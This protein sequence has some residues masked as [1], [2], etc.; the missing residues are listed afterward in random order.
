MEELAELNSA[1]NSLVAVLT[2]PQIGG[3]APALPD[4][5]ALLLGCLDVD[6]IW[7]G[8]RAAI[9]HAAEN[10]AVLILAFLGHGLV[11]GEHATLHLM[12]WQSTEGVAVSAV[13]IKELLG[14][15]ADQL[16]VRGVI[17]LI[18]TCNAAAAQPSIEALTTGARSGRTRI[19]LLMASAVQ[20]TA[21]DLGFSKGLARLLWGGVPAGGEHL[22]M[23]TLKKSLRADAATRR[24]IAFSYDGDSSAPELWLASNRQAGGGAASTVGQRAAEELAA[25]LPALFPN[26]Q[27]SRTW[28]AAALRD[29]EREVGELPATPAQVRVARALDSLVLAERTATFLHSFMPT[30]LN[31]PA[32]RRAMA[33]V[34]AR[35]QSPLDSARDAVERIALNYPVEDGSCR[36]VITRFVVALAEDAGRDLEATE[37]RSWA[38]GIDAL[39][40]YNDA[41]I[42]TRE[43]SRERRLRLVVRLD[44]PA[45]D[46]PESLTAWLLL[47]GA[48]HN[49]SVFTPCPVSQ[50]GAEAK[51][52]EAVEWAE[53]MADDLDLSLQRIEVAVPTRIMLQW[54]PEGAVNGTR[55]GARY[56]V[57]T[58]WSMRL[59][60]PAG[61]RWINKLAQ[62]RLSA[63]AAHDDGSSSIAWLAHH[64]VR[65]HERLRDELENDRLVGPIGLLDCPRGDPE[66]LDLLLPYAP[67]LL[68]PDEVGWS[69]EHCAQVAKRWNDLPDG[70][71]AAYRARWRGN[72]S[73]PMADIRAI[74][75]DDE[76]LAF[77]VGVKR[78]SHTSPGRY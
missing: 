33:T 54:A 4:G 22:G 20:Q 71:L 70:F 72:H 68:W 18:D 30:G 52:I 75:D 78:H 23:G 5:R 14:Q 61:M 58:R 51:L 67:I 36:P 29:L 13:N 34:G 64:E 74:W 63:I 38:L 27:F 31:T 56:D 49:H 3:C 19:D 62:A 8:V 21:Y 45:G 41:V 2:D 26:R 7:S 35:S 1:A 57:R 6:E 9:K 59:D 42:R 76:W 48:V 24:V 55:L 10:G 11:A 65:P 47:D 66:L 44:S 77:C 32:L 15:A 73:D 37:L 16:G 60:P 25:G 40:P 17:G 50:A 53:D 39:L 46:W 43:L 28:T 69:A 12:G